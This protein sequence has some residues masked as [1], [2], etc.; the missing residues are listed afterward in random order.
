MKLENT[1]FGTL[2]VPDDTLITFPQGII[3]FDNL[4]RFI[5][6]DHDT[7]SFI[8]WLQAVEQPELAFV[9]IDP[10]PLVKDYPVERILA[11]CDDLG[12]GPDEEVAIVAVMAIPPAPRPPTVNL[13]APVVMGVGS[14]RGKQVVLHDSPYHTQHP[15]LFSQDG[16]PGA[17]P[18][19]K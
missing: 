2:E 8:R 17:Q 19:S 12:L 15:I 6:L 3:G 14:R 13:L 1:R 4:R 5:I 7:G 18:A 16:Q 9:I 10:L 11:E